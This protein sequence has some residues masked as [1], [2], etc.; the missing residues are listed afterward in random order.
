M[1]KKQTNQLLT[2]AEAAK[3]ARITKP[4]IY[5]HIY[6]S[7]KLPISYM[8]GQLAVSEEKLRKLYPSVPAGRKQKISKFVYT[9]TNE[10]IIA[11]FETL[12]EKV[13]KVSTGTATE[14]ER[15]QMS[16]ALRDLVKK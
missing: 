2:V 11:A 10:E 1:T 16:Y 8:N 6:K 5:Y 3:A 12:G 9:M 15:L 4:T 13:E 7:M 14:Q